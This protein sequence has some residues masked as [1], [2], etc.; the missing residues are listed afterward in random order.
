MLGLANMELV[1]AS[2]LF[3]FDWEL[4]GGVEPEDSDMAERYGIISESLSK[5]YSLNYYLKSLL[6]KNHFLYIFTLQQLL[7]ILCTL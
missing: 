2:F 5:F 6:H 1:L 7:Y 4:P 3:H